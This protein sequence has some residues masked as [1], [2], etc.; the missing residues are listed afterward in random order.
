MEGGF[1]WNISCCSTQHAA[2]SML[3]M[4]NFHFHE[5]S[6]ILLT[7]SNFIDAVLPII[8]AIDSARARQLGGCV[9]KV[10]YE[11]SFRND[12]DL[13]IS[14]KTLVHLHLKTLV[15]GWTS[16]FRQMDRCDTNSTSIYVWLHSGRSRKSTTASVNLDLE[17]IISD[18]KSSFFSVP[19]MYWKVCG[20]GN[21]KFWL[22][23]T[24]DSQSTCA[25]LR[26]RT[27]FDASLGKPIVN[28]NGLTASNMHML[29]H[30]TEQV[31]IKILQPAPFSSKQVPGQFSSIVP[32]L[33]VFY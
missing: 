18:S 11:S 7:K 5:T 33:S 21:H 25:T 30:V 29:L 31:R 27:V 3:T 22:Q 2:T 16:C 1:Y 19:T 14:T 9:E 13:Q 26:R 12:P 6:L 8:W 10:Q 32:I 4:C 24:M 23:I 15:Q 20:C 28:R 17:N